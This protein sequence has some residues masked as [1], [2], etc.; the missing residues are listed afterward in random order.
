MFPHLPIALTALVSL[1]AVV[2]AACAG[3]KPSD[4]L[5]SRDTSPI[6]G[7]ELTPE[8][9]AENEAVTASL[10]SLDACSDPLTDAVDKATIQVFFHVIHAGG[11]V[12]EGN[13]SDS[14]IHEQM[15]ALNGDYKTTGLTFGLAKIVRTFNAD[16]FNNV[17]DKTDKDAAMKNALRQ[18]DATTLNVYT[19][20]FAGNGRLLGYSTFPANYTSFPKRDGVV[21]NYSTLPGGTYAH[22][23]EGSTLTHEAGHWVGLYHTFQGMSCKGPGDYVDDTPAEAEPAYKCV[24][25]NTCPD[26]PGEDPIHNF[27]DYTD[28]ACADNFTPG[29]VDRI[30]TQLR[31]HRGINLAPRRSNSFFDQT[32]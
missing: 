28:D 6:C 10:L 19:V 24:P 20:G 18:G 12:S 14:Q 31:C 15:R 21:I 17:R 22:F 5:M 3:M 25:R 4:D 26:R 1:A 7:S 23:N 11:E 32:L 30:R 29:Q 27:M 8:A 13:I 16:W 2:T 9:I